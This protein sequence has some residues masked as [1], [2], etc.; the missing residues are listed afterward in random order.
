MQNQ[1]RLVAL[2]LQHFPSTTWSL[3]SHRLVASGISV[4]SRAHGVVTDYWWCSLSFFSET[5]YFRAWATGSLWKLCPRPVPWDWH[6][7][8]INSWHLFSVG[9]MV[10]VKAHPFQAFSYIF[11][12]L[13]QGDLRA[14]L[15]QH[16]H[17]HQAKRNSDLIYQL[18]GVLEAVRYLQ[19]K[20]YI[21]RW[22]LL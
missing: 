13:C 21:S 4:R 11:S 9:T 12:S 7:L 8:P 5:Y 22:L 1:E 20:H 18:G 2:G 10:G 3:G 14:R 16:A 15:S 6:D 19:M 17:S